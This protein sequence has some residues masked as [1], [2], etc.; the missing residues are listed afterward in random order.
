MTNYAL[1]GKI[2]ARAAKG[3]RAMLAIVLGSSLAVL[4]AGAMSLAVFTDSDSNGATWTTGTII[5]GVSPTAVF[6]PGVV[7]PGDFDSQTITVANTG[8]GA[9][10]YAMSSSA[11]NTDNKGLASQL[12]LTIDAGPCGSTTG[13]IYSGTLQGAAFGSSAQ[14]ADAGDRPVAAGASEQ[15]CFAWDLPLGTTDAFQNANTTA[16]FTFN[17]E[18]TKNN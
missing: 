1:D 14:G 18:Q 16:T 7:M 17:A 13:S 12:T 10:R 3:R 2:V 11:T 4:G 15:L 6:T 8:T 5:L 9:L